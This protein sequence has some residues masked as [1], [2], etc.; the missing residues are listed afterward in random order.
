MVTGPFKTGSEPSA[1]T[2]DPRGLYIYVA[3]SLRSTISA[4]SI[5]LANGIPST[6]A[7]GYGG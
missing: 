2:V 6:I 3:N 7:G 4:Y 1:V 5:T